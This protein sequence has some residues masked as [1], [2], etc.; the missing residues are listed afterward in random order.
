[1]NMYGLMQSKKAI[2]SKDVE[3]SMDGN[4]CRCTGYRPIFDAMKSLASDASEEL[5]RK[6]GTLNVS[7]T[8]CV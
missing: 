4:I 2:T 3:D 5:K 6:C 1:M 7:R 8:Q